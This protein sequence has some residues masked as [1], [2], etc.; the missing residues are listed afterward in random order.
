MKFLLLPLLLLP[1]S[2][3]YFLPPPSRPLSLLRGGS[4][5]LPGYDLLESISCETSDSQK[6]LLSAFSNLSSSSAQKLSSQ[7][8]T[9]N[10]S[11]PTGLLSYIQKSRQLLAASGS[12]PFEEYIP[13][14][15]SGL[16]LNYE[17]EKFEELEKQGLSVC[18]DSA[19]VLVAGGL[20]ERL[21]YS[22]IKISLSP[23]SLAL[24]SDN[25]QKT[26]LDLYLD[27]VRAVQQRTGKRMKFCIM[28]S[29]DTDELTRGLVEG[30]QD[31]E[32]EIVM[33][34]KGETRRWEP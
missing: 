33:Q 6:S 31:L 28:T 32:V 13:S 23:Y 7:I 1:S 2:S 12:N 4:S 25:T 24:K 29:G 18:G 15:P 3:S 34:E 8:I 17:D 11:Y 22:G 9:L 20:G 27:Y 16:N 10:K 14:V 21:G 26:Y 30:V 19:I 5:S